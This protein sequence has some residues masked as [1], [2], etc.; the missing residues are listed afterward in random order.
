MPKIFKLNTQKYGLQTSMKEVLNRYVFLGLRKISPL[1][2]HEWEAKWH[3]KARQD[4]SSV[5]ALISLKEKYYNLRK[6][7]RRGSKEARKVI[8]ER[9]I[10]H[11]FSKIPD[12][13]CLKAA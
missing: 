4:R 12:E 9:I 8:L 7:S 1:P 13:C 6:L 10:A 11:N 3:Y 2:T 5:E